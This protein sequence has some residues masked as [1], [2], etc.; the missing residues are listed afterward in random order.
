MSA[1][2]RSPRRPSRFFPATMAALLALGCGSFVDSGDDGASTGSGATGTSGGNA[3]GATG[4]GAGA[5]A[6]S[7]QSTTGATGSSG[8]QMDVPANEYCGGVTDWD[9]EWTTLEDE[10]LIIVNENRAAGATCGGDSMPPVEPLRMDEALRCAAR[11]HSQDMAER[12]Y[13]DHD[14][15]DGDG[16]VERM[17][18]AGYSGRGWGE[19]IAAGNATA[20][21]TM[22]QWMESSGHCSNIMSEGFGL[23]GV[24]YYPGG[25]YGHLWTQTFGR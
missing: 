15:P 10:I 24:G 7:G 14:N 1:R 11:V 21:R 6:S 23:I 17:Q 16:P 8:G 25:E 20:A 2:T 3:G 19:N 4:S 22:M 5:S 13:F 18:A 12:D 9:P